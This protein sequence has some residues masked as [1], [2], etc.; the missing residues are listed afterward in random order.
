MAGEHFDSAGFEFKRIPETQHKEW[1]M[2]A[3]RDT[4]SPNTD[5]SVFP[6]INHENLHH[7]SQPDRKHPDPLS[8][9][10]LSSSSSPSLSSFS[11]S[12]SDESGPLSPLPFDT[13]VRK[14]GEFTTWVGIGFGLLRSKV[15]AM[16]SS[17]GFD[18]VWSFASGAGMAA[19]VFVLWSL[20]LRAWQRRY[21]NDLKLIRKEKDEKINK[22]LHQIAQMNEVLV[23]RHKALAS[24]LVN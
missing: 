14:P 19:V 6:P 5:S 2:V 1:S 22:L 20:F 10:S 16:A 12:D 17:S 9:P 3:I 21:R 18:K 8:S 24:K 15:S 23:A 11:P 13:L 4:P 7:P